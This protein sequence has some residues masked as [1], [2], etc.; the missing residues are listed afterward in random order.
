[1]RVEI[2][3]HKKAKG[4]FDI[5]LMPGGLVDLEFTVQTL[6]LTHRTA[7][8]TSL[9]DAIDQ[10]VESNLLPPEIAK[11]HRL[12]ARLLI[13]LRLVSPESGEPPAASHGLV[14]RAAKREGWDTLLAD[15]AAA[16]DRIKAAWAQV[17]G[18]A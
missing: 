9:C 14:A 18:A 11:A 4:A 3:R 17:S 10:L 13:I 8:T 15:K 16:E 2:A 5:K 6:Q 7:L 12:I 1:M